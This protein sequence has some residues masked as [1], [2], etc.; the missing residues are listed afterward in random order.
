MRRTIGFLVALVALFGVFTFSFAQPGWGPDVLLSN[1]N[2]SAELPKI[3]RTGCIVHVSWYESSGGEIYYVRSTDNGGTWSAPLF[4]GIMTNPLL[5]LAASDN[6]V[7]VA[8]AIGAGPRCVYRRSTDYGVTWGRYDTVTFAGYSWP[9]LGVAGDS[10][11]LLMYDSFVIRTVLK[12]STDRGLTWGPIQQVS[13]LGSEGFAVR[14]PVIHVSL[15][16]WDSTQHSPEVAYTKSM[17]GGVSWT[18]FVTL[19]D[20]DG[21][22]SQGVSICSDQRYG[23]HLT[24]WDGKFTPY[25]WTGDIF[26]RTS[27]DT[28]RTW[29]PYD[30]LTVEHRAKYPNIITQG[31]TLHIAWTDD[32]FQPDTNPEI[33]YRMS[34]DLG[35][36]WQTPERLT[37]KEGES[38]WPQ[39]AVGDSFLHLVWTDSRPD[40]LPGY[41]Q[42]YY[43]RKALFPSGV[44]GPSISCKGLDGSLVRVYPNP[45]RGSFWIYCPTRG[46]V[47]IYD[48]TGKLVRTLSPA[49]SR[50]TSYEYFWDGRDARGKEVRSGE[51]FIQLRTVNGVKVVKKVTVLRGRK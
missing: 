48:V 40:S 10:V 18:P 24:W 11:Y 34:M 47:S 49:A 32:R 22:S 2:S 39:L 38:F 26:W 27:R 3:A 45:S 14:S 37:F 8:W 20:S 15:G 44:K 50:L 7:H 31:E 42:T 51:Y 23:P 4:I 25:P 28:G 9:S 6:F 29:E 36:T 16:L 21:F 12:R 1:S 43:K 30:T 35:L 5:T 19:S 33:F 13:T 46:M 17:D 41:R